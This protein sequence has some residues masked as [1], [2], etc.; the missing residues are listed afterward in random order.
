MNTTP[1]SEF[2][3]KTDRMM[4]PKKILDMLAAVGVSVSRAT[5]ERWIKTK[6]FPAPSL[7]VGRT[8]RWT[9]ASVRAWLEQCVKDAKG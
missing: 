4:K 1:A 3:I 5:F 2:D 8:R 6:Y 9:E 7:H